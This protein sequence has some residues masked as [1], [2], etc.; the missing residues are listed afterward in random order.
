MSTTELVKT[1]PRIDRQ[2]P[3]Y[4]ELALSK[5]G[6]VE[7]IGARIARLRREKGLTQVELA[8]ALEVSQPV[9]SDYENDV[10]KL[11]GETIVALTQ[12]LG[13]SADEILGLEKPARAAGATIR[14][15]RIYRQLQSID[16]LPKRDQEALARTIDAFLSKGQ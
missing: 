8:K 11:S 1:G 2:L 9:V 10:I 15:R 4:E 13:A 7:S 14:N 12:I 5:A 16:R 6:A 3:L